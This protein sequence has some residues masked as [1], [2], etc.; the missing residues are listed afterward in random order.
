MSPT[1]AI[2]VNLSRRPAITVNLSRNV[3]VKIYQLMMEVFGI[4]HSS[5]IP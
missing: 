1:A 3:I 5:V 2:T 4:K